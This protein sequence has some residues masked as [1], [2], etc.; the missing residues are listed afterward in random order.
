MAGSSV[1]NTDLVN[2]NNFFSS[3]TLH[4]VTIILFFNKHFV[5]IYW[6]QSSGV[7]ILVIYEILDLGAGICMIVFRF[8]FLR[9]YGLWL[10]FV[11]L[12]L[13]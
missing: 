10:C 5:I 7:V 12:M 1:G 11:S 8:P 9:I 6:Q 3:W 4:S 13:S 2:R